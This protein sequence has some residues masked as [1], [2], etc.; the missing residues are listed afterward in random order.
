VKKRGAGQMKSGDIE[1]I[2]GINIY[3]E[4]LIQLV[5]EFREKIINGTKDPENFLT[6]SEIEHLWSELKGNTSILY[7][8]MLEETLSQIDE[9]ELVNKKKQNI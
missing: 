6:I 4:E 3:T 9:T 8:N 1:D 5:D 2:K 7:S